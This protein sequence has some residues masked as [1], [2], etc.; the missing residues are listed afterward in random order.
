MVLTLKGCLRIEGWCLLDLK[1]AWFPGAH[2]CIIVARM[3]S[4]PHSLVS[5]S[6]LC[7]DMA[8]T[9]LAWDAALHT[10][11]D[12]LMS[13]YTQFAHV[14]HCRSHCL[15]V[16]IPFLYFTCRRALLD[17]LLS[18][19]FKQQ[20][21][22]RWWNFCWGRGRIAF[23]VIVCFHVALGIRMVSSRHLPKWSSLYIFPVWVGCIS[24][25]TLC[26]L[27]ALFACISGPGLSVPPKLKYVF[28]WWSTTP[29]SSIPTW[30][31]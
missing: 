26:F 10:R 19:S 18:I 24:W 20:S 2:S 5:Q 30:K 6:V 7:H 28:G 4:M 12:I 3:C 29:P 1:C 27:V 11:R 21:P 25:P 14:V 8:A 9:V 13:L 31:A 22:L 15:H 23:C 16:S 17:V